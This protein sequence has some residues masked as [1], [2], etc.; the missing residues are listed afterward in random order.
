MSRLDCVHAFRRIPPKCISEPVCR[1]GRALRRNTV[2][3]LRKPDACRTLATRTR[4]EDAG[5]DTSLRPLNGNAVAA[6]GS[7]GTRARPRGTWGPP[8]TCP[9]TPSGDKTRGRVAAA[10]VRRP[11]CDD[12]RRRRSWRPGWG[13]TRGRGEQRPWRNCTRDRG[14]PDG[15]C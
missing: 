9:Q 7:A 5:G 6:D 14:C 13:K 10:S 3:S 11:H 15:C 2:T 1:R 4:T 12:R 8:E